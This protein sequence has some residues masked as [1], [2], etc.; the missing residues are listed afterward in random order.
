MNVIKDSVIDENNHR[1]QETPAILKWHL[2]I[3]YF[4]YDTWFVLSIKFWRLDNIDV[5]QETN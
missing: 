2:A 3:C 1:D 5:I 4:F